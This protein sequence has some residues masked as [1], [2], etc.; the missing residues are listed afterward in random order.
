MTKDWIDAALVIFRD[1][2]ELPA[3]ER[4]AFVAHACAGDEAL[5]GHVEAMLAWDD[6]GAR[7]EHG[8]EVPHAVRAALSHLADQ[9][10]AAA[11]ATSIPERIGAYRIVR[12]IARGGMG[13]VYE[14]VQEQPARRV[15]I[16]VARI[17]GTTGERARRFQLEGQLLARLNH[18]GIAQIIEA[19]T[20][21]LE[22]GAQ[23]YFVM[24]FVD[25][26]SLAEHAAAHLPT[27]LAKVALMARVCEAVGFAHERD[28]I[29]RDLKPDNVLIAANG[30]PKVLDFGVAKVESAGAFGAATLR[31]EAGRVL[32]TIGY[33]APEQ[34]GG[35]SA[36]LGPQ[37]DVYSLGVMLY[38][39]LSG[40]LPHELDAVTPTQALA[41]VTT[42][43]A[44]LLGVV[45]PE[46]R[47][48][49]EAVVAKALEKDYRHRYAD[50]TALQAD[51][52]RF[53]RGEPVQAR[54][55]GPVRRVTKWSR[56]NPATA[57]AVFGLFLA[58][59][60]VAATMVAKNQEVRTVLDDVQQLDDIYVLADLIEKAQV[61]GAPLADGGRRELGALWP[62]RP[63]QI[64]ALQRWIGDCTRLIAR[65]DLH[66]AA[67]A[68][69]RRQSG[70]R[71]DGETW[72]FA[73]PF[74]QRQHDMLVQ[75]L[76]DLEG[77]RGERGVLRQVQQRLE[78]ANSIERLTVQDWQAA[79]D[80]AR[81]RIEREPN[82]RFAAERDYRLELRPQVGLIPLGP[83]PTSR[84]EE[85]LHLET[86]AGPVPHRDGDGHLPAMAGA[87]G[88]IFVLIPRGTFWMG[89]QSDDEA[90]HNYD[91]G[92]IGGGPFDPNRPKS[93]WEALYEVRD[94]GPFLLSK[95][96]MTEAQWQ[97]LVGGNPVLRPDQSSPTNP[98][99]N[100]SYKQCDEVLRRL[101]LQL[102]HEEQWEYAA[103]ATTQTPWWT[104]ADAADLAGA[105]AL[106]SASSQEI[107]A[108]WWAK[109]SGMEVAPFR[110]PVVDQLLLTA[111]EAIG[112]GV[113]R[114]QAL[115]TARGVRSV[116]S[117]RANRFG[118]FDVGGNVA[119]WCANHPGY[120]VPRER[121]EVIPIRMVRGGY[122]K[123]GVK[124]ARSA[125]R[126]EI[127]WDTAMGELGV[128]PAMALAP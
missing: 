10:E 93:R 16:K 17:S 69:L 77:L 22:V 85:F 82:Y 105:E 29:H 62:T 66:E 74:V 108:P 103:R 72:T 118:L 121:D 87:T 59:S 111:Q 124:C 36:G 33:M 14:A 5:R 34:L 68:R 1:A 88:L 43:D 8:V 94:I 55:A 64:D 67:L 48:E 84:L 106:W 37:A 49:I 76:R 107:V 52:E 122:Y 21:N 63:A 78:L 123:S 92:A 100:V 58:V 81:Q 60:A 4:A 12:L 28:V 73:V 44:P 110:D 27:T 115:A 102:P 25:G 26:Q 53:L 38:Q 45:R 61:P 32:G 109:K 98:V 39:L 75:L 20:T 6:R 42:T 97:R 101:G 79:W 31:T 113:P 104:G 120:K 117:Y 126:H 18:P 86:H 91:P 41:V 80:A 24:E 19:G 90:G 112:Q 15:A 30:Q 119:E 40:R 125:W 7:Q 89:C 3:A 47:G 11:D 56:R 128:R 96:E 9:A 127:P 65:H 46:L 95:Y 2:C 70:K 51:L 99:C 57:S 114:A 35:K 71:V 13:V 50:A 54:P 23:P 116:G 83:D